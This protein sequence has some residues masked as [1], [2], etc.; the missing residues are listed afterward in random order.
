MH[1]IDF[2]KLASWSICCF[3]KSFVFDLY[4]DDS[5]ELMPYVNKVHSDLHL[6][7]WTQVGFYIDPGTR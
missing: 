7:R 1:F 5:F 2:V 3:L 6:V 4:E